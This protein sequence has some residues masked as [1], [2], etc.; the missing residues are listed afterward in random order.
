RERAQ[1]LSQELG[2]P[3]APGFEVFV[4]RTRRGITDVGRWTYVRRDGSTFRVQLAVSAVRDPEGTLLGFVGLAQDVTEHE[5]AHEHLRQS[6]QRL[7][8]VIETASDAFIA[9]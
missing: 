7:R 3:I 5:L 4:A 9:I 6:E 1:Q 8:T 2:T